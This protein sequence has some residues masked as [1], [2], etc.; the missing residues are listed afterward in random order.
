[1]VREIKYRGKPHNQELGKWVYGSLI[2]YSDGSKAIF[3]DK[4][5]KTPVPIIDGTEGQYTG[6]KDKNGVEIYEGDIVKLQKLSLDDRLYVAEVKWQVN[7]ARYAFV[8]D[9]HDD[10]GKLFYE[11]YEVNPGSIEIIG[12]IHEN[13]ELLGEE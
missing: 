6:L 3:N 10:N 1:M 5:Y 12:N 8:I 13:P 4:E 7:A 11:Y 9:Y 2:I